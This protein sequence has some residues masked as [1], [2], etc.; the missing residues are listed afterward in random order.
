MPAAEAHDTDSRRDPA[1][2]K[3]TKDR[4]AASLAQRVG[5]GTRRRAGDEGHART[6]VL[7]LGSERYGISLDCVDAIRFPSH[8]TPIP[9]V[10]SFVAGVVCLVGEVLTLVD[11]A[12]LLHALPSS[13]KADPRFV[14]VKIE[15]DLVA[16]KVDAVEGVRV[17]TDVRPFS[18]PE[19]A[20]AWL[21]E[22]QIQGVAEGTIVLLDLP[23]VLG[24]DRA[25]VDQVPRRSSTQ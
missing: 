20:D 3:A 18:R 2:V 1:F 6:L 5:D 23:R 15:Q 12:T 25:R 8:V 17:F 13:E 4:R 22:E 11:L 10:P 14:I 19:V 24:D 9:G 21:S 16:L 7:R